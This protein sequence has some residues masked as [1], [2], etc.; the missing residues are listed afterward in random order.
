MGHDQI[1]VVVLF[2]DTAGISACDGFLVQG[3]ENRNPLEQFMPGDPRD[4]LQFVNH[5]R[6]GDI[7]LCPGNHR[8]NIGRQQSAQI[9]RML[10]L[11]GMDQVV[12]Q[13]FVYLVNA[14]WN[15]FDQAT[16]ANHCRKRLNIDI[17]LQKRIDDQ[18][19]PESEL[20]RHLFIRLQLL[21]RMAQRP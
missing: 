7:S 15:R 11:R 1:Q 2:A 9:G 16:P 12:L 18:L 3:V 21:G 4:I 6:I 19:L 20:V 14:R 5:H 8:S 10:A 13:R 17:R